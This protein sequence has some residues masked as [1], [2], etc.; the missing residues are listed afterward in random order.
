MSM[1]WQ[2]NYNTTAHTNTI[3]AVRTNGRFTLA[4]STVMICPGVIGGN[5]CT[6]SCRFMA[7]WTLKPM[8]LQQR[9]PT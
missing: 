8:N 6:W 5:H 3:W 2:T 7:S 1:V 4:V 9:V